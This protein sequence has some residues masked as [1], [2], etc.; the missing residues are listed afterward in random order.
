[1]DIFIQVI[2]KKYMMFKR[3]S[4]TGSVKRLFS[5]VLPYQNPSFLRAILHSLRLFFPIVLADR[6]YCSQDASR[7]DVSTVDSVIRAHH[8]GSHSQ[9]L[10]I[11]WCTL[12]EDS[13]HFEDRQESVW[14]TNIA[15]NIDIVFASSTSLGTFV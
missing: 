1:M 7:S 4:A 14:K 3:V 13:L 2:C 8:G 11:T 15:R 5:F 12:E 9:H 6:L 10:P